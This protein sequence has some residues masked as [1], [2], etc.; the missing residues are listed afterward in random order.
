MDELKR[1]WIHN[2][3]TSNELCSINRG[4]KQAAVISTLD[5]AVK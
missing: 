5:K 4:Q 1:E 3:K 2:K